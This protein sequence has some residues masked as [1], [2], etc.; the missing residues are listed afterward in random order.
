M[1]RNSLIGRPVSSEISAKSLADGAGLLAVL[2]GEL[3][4]T[5][6]RQ[7][8][9]PAHPARIELPALVVF[10][11]LGPRHAAVGG[12]AHQ[13]A[14]QAQEPLVLVVELLDQLLDPGIVQPDIPHVLDQL[15]LQLLVPGL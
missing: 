12:H 1:R 15:Q 6:A 7:A 8:L 14:F 3:F 10:Q 2:L 13:L 4:P 11:E 5:L 9:D